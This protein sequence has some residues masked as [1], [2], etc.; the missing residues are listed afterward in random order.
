MQADA[1]SGFGKLYRPGRKA[2][3]FVE[4]ACGAHARRKFFELA[5]LKK[6]PMAVA[7]VKRIDALFEVERDINGLPPERRAA[8]RDERSR[9]LVVELEAWLRENRRALSSK[10]TTANAI[11][12]MLKRWSS[13]TRLLDDGRICLSHK[14]SDQR[15]GGQERDRQCRA[16]C[17]P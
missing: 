7:A 6:A 14:R 17:T 13:F 12:Y 2:G 16:P 8:A 15:R 4:A 10:S 5:D 1:F 9:P 3:E 11:D